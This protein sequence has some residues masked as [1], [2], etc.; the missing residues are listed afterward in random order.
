MKKFFLSLALMLPI[1]TFSKEKD[2]YVIVPMGIVCDKAKK[3]L[4]AIKE[5]DEKLVFVGMEEGGVNTISLW[6]NDATGSFTVILTPKNADYS[7]I[8]SSGQTSRSI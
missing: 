2:T 3:V 4:D 1:I 6:K 5:Y 7:C 8:V